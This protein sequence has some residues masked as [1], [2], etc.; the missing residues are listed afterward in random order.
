MQSG[1][2]TEAV[3]LILIHVEEMNEIVTSFP[4]KE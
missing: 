3:D 1:I 4:K 2:Q